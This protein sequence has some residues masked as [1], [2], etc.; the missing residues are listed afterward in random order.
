MAVLVFYVWTIR[1]NGTTLIQLICS[2][3]KRAN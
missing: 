3:L 2:Q 1:F